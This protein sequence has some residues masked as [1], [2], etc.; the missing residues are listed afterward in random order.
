MAKIITNL[1]NTGDIDR[2]SQLINDGEDNTSRFVEENELGDVAFSNDYN[3]LDNLPF[4]PTQYTN[5]D[6]QDAIGSILLDTSTI[7]LN[8]NDLT[9]SISASVK[10]NSITATELSNSINIS[11]FI[12]DSGYLVSSNFKTVEGQ[13]IVGVG[14]IDLSK[15]DVG[16]NNVDNTSDLNKP[17]S[18]AT[19]T[20]LNLKEDKA[21]KGIANGY[22]PTDASNLIPIGF[23]PPSVIERLVIVADQTARFA[24]TTATVQNGDTVKQADTNVMY[25]VKD[26]TNLSNSNGYE[27]YRAGTAASVPW[28]GV[29]G[30]PTTQAGYGIIPQLGD[31]DTSLVPDTLN[32]RYQTDSQK[33]Y[34][35]ATSSIQTQLNSKEPSITASGNVTDFWSG[36]KTF[37]D[38]ATD[39]RN[40]VLTGFN[41]V[42]T[43][44]RVTT[45]TT[46]QDAI[47]LLQR[48]N[49]YL[50][51]TRF[52]SGVGVTINTDPTKFDIQVIGEIV[53]INTF[54]P[55]PINI[56]LTAQ[57]TT[58]IGTQAES[59]IWIN[60]VGTV[61]QSLTPPTPID[62]D[63]IIGYWVLVHSN[64]STIT[65]VNAFP[66]YADGINTKVS[67]ILSF[68]GF[69]KFPNTN[70]ASAGTIGTRLAH[71]GGFAIKAGIG[72]TT[73]RPVISLIGATDPS[74]M[75][76][77]HRNGTYTTGVQNIDVTSYNS[78]G[79]TISVL[80]NN[81]FTVHKI[82]KFSSSL[83]RIQY[84][85]HE[86]SSY[87]EAAVSIDIDSY[88]DEGNAFRNGLHIGWLIFKKNTSW[89]I[90]GTGVEGVD[91]KFIDV[92]SNGSVGGITP[93]LQATYDVSVQPQIL[94][95]DTLGALTERSNRALNTSTIHEWQ[96][97]A[98]TTTA[99][100]NGNG[101][102]IGTYGKF[103]TSTNV[104]APQITVTNGSNPSVI[105]F[106]KTGFTM[107]GTVGALGSYEMNMSTN[108]DYTTSP[109]THR[110]YD[111][112]K[113]ATWLAIGDSFW[114]MQYAPASVAALTADTYSRVGE[115][116]GLCVA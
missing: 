69:S 53:D 46:I 70:I 97:I 102:I 30:T 114:Q 71:T 94:I 101:D 39:V 22:V 57:T 28:S 87:S 33:L 77:R 3:D 110:F 52:I 88:I 26:D 81:K 75:E 50:Q 13:T 62:F 92:R 100:V 65:I 8:Y 61:V 38:L 85:Q 55:T 32:A 60:S 37:R 44:A 73:K 93:T 15:S 34:N 56:N 112:T 74:N 98:G 24:L 79:S 27:I 51:S 80:A 4:I 48:Q 111:N 76:M 66:I 1:G 29:T 84:G 86:Y 7:D 90:G 113:D 42:I 25:Y 6:A 9:P 2:T 72:N 43:W 63:N 82:W 64:L 106:P 47:S 40:V 54:I 59:Y 36:I 95:N 68:I 115:A 107:V 116:A 11:E 105:E 78:S 49:N 99:S 89:G 108:M 21:N 10:S 91:Y 5:E 41:S 67:Q 17:I 83:I 12:N 103:G 109:G 20:A 45:S 16:L 18:T 96:N 19:Q 31:Y 23:I 104:T 35:D 58:F 14:N